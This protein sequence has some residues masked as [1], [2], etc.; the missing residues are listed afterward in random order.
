MFQNLQNLPWFYPIEEHL[1]AGRIF[2]FY[3]V[4]LRCGPYPTR[5][6]GLVDPHDGRRMPKID[7][8]FQ[9]PPFPPKK[10][11]KNPLKIHKPLT[12]RASVKD[13]PL[14]Q[15]LSGA[16]KVLA[17]S[18]NRPLAASGRLVGHLHDGVPHELSDLQPDVSQV[19]S[20][21]RLDGILRQ[22]ID[23]GTVPTTC[24]LTTATRM[25]PDE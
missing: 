18:L 12:F 23:D 9:H 14:Y 17:N 16:L 10:T 11:R 20:L 21:S 7:Q 2:H 19:Q 15:A 24:Y 8:K 25:T 6:R 13:P 22:S 3:A 1:Q 4:L 5:T